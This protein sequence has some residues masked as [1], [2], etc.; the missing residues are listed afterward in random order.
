V[1]VGTAIVRKVLESSSVA[2][3]ETELSEFVAQ[4]AAAVR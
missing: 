1:I 2:E 3:A 4:L